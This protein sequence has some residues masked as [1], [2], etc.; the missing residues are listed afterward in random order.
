MGAHG[1]KIDLIKVSI[2]QIL[3]FFLILFFTLAWCRMSVFPKKNRWRSIEASG[4]S[5]GPENE[6]RESTHGASSASLAGPISDRVVKPVA[7]KRWTEKNKLFHSTSGKV[8]G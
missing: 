8:D 1:V 6:E 2:I 5:T 3:F 7:L 4:N